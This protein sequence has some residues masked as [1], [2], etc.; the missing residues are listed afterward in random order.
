MSSLATI[1]GEPMS[2]KPA[3]VTAGSRYVAAA[4][5]SAA[6]TVRHELP[7]PVGF[8]ACA[9]D[10]LPGAEVNDRGRASSKRTSPG[11]SASQSG[12]VNA[13]ITEEPPQPCVS[14]SSG[15]SAL[16]EPFRWRAKSWSV[17]ALTVAMSPPRF[18]RG[19]PKS[20]AKR[21]AISALGYFARVFR[22]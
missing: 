10:A 15:G 3:P 22:Q 2:V 12:A 14:I 19:C 18:A 4:G 20:S 6:G 17:R 8:T 21:R 1:V 7:G 13:P 16:P 5:S 9:F 11:W